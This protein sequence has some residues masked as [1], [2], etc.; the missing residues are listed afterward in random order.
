MIPRISGSDW[1][2]VASPA[3]PTP[4]YALRSWKS[5]WNILGNLGK[6]PNYFSQVN[7]DVLELPRVAPFPEP[8]DPALGASCVRLYPVS[9]QIVLEIYEAALSGRAVFEGHHPI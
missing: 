4:R 1:K 7:V 2:I 5:T 8:A 6:Y 9:G 3:T